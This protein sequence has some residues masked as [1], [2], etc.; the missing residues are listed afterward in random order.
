MRATAWT[1]L[2][3]F[4]GAVE[5]SARAI[6]EA[7]GVTSAMIQRDDRVLSTPRVSLQF[8]VSGCPEHY[9]FRPSNAEFF[10][11]IWEGTLAVE[12]LTDR[13]RNPEQ[14]ALLRSVARYYLAQPLLYT[15]ALM[16]FHQLAKV[17]PGQCSPS[18]RTEDN[19]D[20][21]VVSFAMTLRIRD[22]AWPASTS[23]PLTV[24][25]TDVL[26]DNTVTIDQLEI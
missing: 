6:L 5:G 3:D 25:R 23:I 17:L 15:E 21:S 22:D 2:Y 4:E 12:I 9:G 7:N 16:P 26:V 8:T 20:I 10:L 24:D 13:K 18:I 14:H 1:D 19:E 11:D